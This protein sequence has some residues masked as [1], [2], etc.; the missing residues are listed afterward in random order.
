MNRSALYISTL[1]VL[2]RTAHAQPDPET[3]SEAPG[4]TPEAA[5]PPSET[6]PT[7]TPPSDTPPSDTPA[8]DT[9]AKEP[10]PTAWATAGLEEDT[11]D[12]LQ[13]H[14]WVSQGA[15]LSTGN[16]YLASTKR[17]SFELFDAGVN[18]TK[19]LG[20]NIRAGIQL[21]AQDLGPIGNYNP[22]V[23]WAYVDYRVKPWL[24]FRAG[25]FK[26]PLFLYSDQLDVDMS[27]STVLMPQSV[28]DQHFR[29][30]LAAVSGLDVYGT[31]DLG[32]AGTVDYDAY[33]GTLYIQPRGTTYDVESLV[34]SRVVWN[35]PVPCVKV[36]GHVLYGNFH[37][38]RE[39]DAMTT[40]NVAYNDWTMAGGA[41]ECETEKFTL[42]AEASTW[43]SAIEFTPMLQPPAKYKEL[44]AYGQATFRATDRLT[45]S[46]YLS[47]YHNEYNDADWSLPENHQYDA[48]ASLRYDV[49]PHLLVKAEAHAIDGWGLTEN[50]LNIDNDRVDRWGMFLLKTTLTY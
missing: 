1:L 26:M 23:D 48:A 6:P 7:E 43:R 45:A 19:E 24:G 49:T 34:G 35:T 36:A 40:I 15:M 13:I 39:I 9:P 47:I 18:V 33:V 41:L 14:G 20:S 29:D 2:A 25:H 27:R 28:Y 44:R 37:E 21:F 30:V 5:A 12:S 50:S 8:S 46:V 42:T 31:V 10:E 17:G 3:P 32:A 4:A 22:I 16:N 38:K 11:S